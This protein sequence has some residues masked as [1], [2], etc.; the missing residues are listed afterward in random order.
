VPGTVL[1][2]YSLSFI[3]LCRHHCSALSFTFIHCPSSSCVVI[4]HCTVLHYYS[5]SF[6]VLCRHHCSALSSTFIHCR[7]SSCVV[8]TVLHCPPLLFTVLHR[9]ASSQMHCP[10]LLL[11]VLHRPVSSRLHCPILQNQCHFPD[12]RPTDWCNFK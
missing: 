11:T 1:H 10:P 12:E 8:T 4:M 5:L 6:I 7:S 3:V 9:P 2:F